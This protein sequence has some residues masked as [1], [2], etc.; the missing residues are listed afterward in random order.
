MV[1]LVPPF[2]SHTYIYELLRFFW[3]LIEFLNWV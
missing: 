3:N 2:P 1:L